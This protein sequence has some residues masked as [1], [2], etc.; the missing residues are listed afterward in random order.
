MEHL[1]EESLMRTP[2]ESYERL[3]WERER[4]KNLSIDNGRSQTVVEWQSRRK[5]EEADE[6]T[7]EPAEVNASAL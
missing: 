6:A 2:Q 7:S 5:G 1:S 3:V 4:R